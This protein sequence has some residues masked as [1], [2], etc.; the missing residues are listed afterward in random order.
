MKDLAALNVQVLKDAV[1]ALND[2]GI[3]DPKIN[4]V[5]KSKE[6]LIEE[7]R[8]FI[9]AFPEDRDEEIPQIVADFYNEYIAEEPVPE[10]EKTTMKKEKESKKKKKEEKVPKPKERVVP[11]E[12]KSKAR[13]K[14]D[15]KKQA[16]KE[17]KMVNTNDFGAREGCQ[18]FT[19]DALLVNGKST[20]KQL[21][22]AAET[23]L[24]RIRSH[25]A[26]RKAQGHLVE[27]S[28]EAKTY[29][30]EAGKGELKKK[31]KK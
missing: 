20:L 7:F 25:I 27:F 30:M 18:T 13:E 16:A 5:G 21:A 15:E 11:E 19:I 2:S 29:K 4:V 10:E 1:K 8:S 9:N 12:G 17:K 23:T 3:I 26:A 31:G 22:D 14:A 24:T 28:K 6:K